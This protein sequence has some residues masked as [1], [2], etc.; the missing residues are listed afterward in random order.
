MDD[1]LVYYRGYYISYLLSASYGTMDQNGNVTLQ[2]T[3]NLYASSENIGNFM[4]AVSDMLN[5]IINGG[6]VT[7]AMIAKA[8]EA[9]QVLT[10]N[11]LALFRVLAGAENYVAF[12]SYV[13]SDDMDP[14]LEKLDR[15][16]VKY[17]LLQ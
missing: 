6:D 15:I 8:K 4:A 14:M 9:M 1:A 13:L 7:D 10:E 17:G 12:M 16:K 5:A 11:E 2:P 3:W